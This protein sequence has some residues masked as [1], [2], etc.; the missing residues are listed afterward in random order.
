MVKLQNQTNT[1]NP[2]TPKSKVPRAL[3]FA[4]LA[5]AI[6]LGVQHFTGGI[7]P[8]NWWVALVAA[9]AVGVASTLPWHSNANP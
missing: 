6:Y 7:A 1:M 9:I 3:V 8:H 2:G 5:V 4:L